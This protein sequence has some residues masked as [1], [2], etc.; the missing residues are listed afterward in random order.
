M[1]AAGWSLGYIAELRSGSPFGV[2]EASNRTG[3]FSEGNRPNVVG[4]PYLSPD[5]SRADRISRWFNT[6][7]F[8]APADFTF[9][10]A[11]KTVGYGPGAINMDISLLRDFRIGERHRLQ[12]RGE[13]LNFLNRPNFANPVIARGN[14]A[15]G[16]ITGLQ[17]GNQNRIVQ[18]G[19]RYSF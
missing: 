14:A 3:S 7:A 18:L 17:P 15:F 11:G 2:T 4:D 13:S 19:L 1:V 6:S 9:G 16:R 12:F 8:A 10:N 5:R